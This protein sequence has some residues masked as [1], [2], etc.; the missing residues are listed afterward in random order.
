[1]SKLKI[2]RAALEE[3]IAPV[4]TL[5][6]RA[7]KN[8]MELSSQAWTICNSGSYLQDVARKALAEMDA[9]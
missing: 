7:A 4:A 1:M 6:A 3:I 5:K 8:G 9:K 2:A